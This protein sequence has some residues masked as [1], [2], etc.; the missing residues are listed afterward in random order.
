MWCVNVTEIMQ[1]KQNNTES[2]TDMTLLEWN[3]N[4]TELASCTMVLQE[5]IYQSIM[6]VGHDIGSDVSASNEIKA[7]FV[8]QHVFKM[9]FQK[10]VMNRTCNVCQ[11][12][13]VAIFNN[14]TNLTSVK[15]TWKKTEVTLAWNARKNKIN[16]EQQ[17]HMNKKEDMK[18]KATKKKEIKCTCK[19]CRN[20]NINM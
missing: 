4:W 13:F 10:P 8:R 15:K 17:I 2:E 3:R 20:I 16:Y 1:Q 9:K 5:W 18:S 19:L 12:D 6:T 7:S 11:K 14:I